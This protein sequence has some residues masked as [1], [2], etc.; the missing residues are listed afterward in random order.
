MSVN[1][2]VGIPLIRRLRLSLDFDPDT[3]ISHTLK[4]IFPVKFIETS[5]FDVKVPSASVDSQIPS[6]IAAH[7]ALATPLAPMAIPLSLQVPL[8]YYLP[9]P[10]RSQQLL[11]RPVGFS[12]PIVPDGHPPR[13]TQ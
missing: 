11:S 4:K 8:N 5:L 7:T 1:A 12:D 2:I 13:Q 3:I 10:S 9:E 6:A